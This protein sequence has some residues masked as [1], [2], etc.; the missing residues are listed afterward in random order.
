MTTTTTT[1]RITIETKATRAH[2]TYPYLE[3]W[4][5]VPLVNAA[6]QEMKLHVRGYGVTG[7][8]HARL[9]SP[10]Y[11]VT[12]WLSVRALSIGTFMRALTRV[13]CINKMHRRTENPGAFDWVRV[14]ATH[15]QRQWL[16]YHMCM[17]Q[18]IR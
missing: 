10:L 4:V 3:L 11:P 5:C 15:P 17:C 6:T 8:M 14:C 12:Q 18:C 2:K 16:G 1:L 13:L 7:Q 9:S